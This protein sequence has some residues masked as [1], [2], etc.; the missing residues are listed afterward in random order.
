MCRDGSFEVESQTLALT[1]G[2]A[3]RAGL[4]RLTAMLLPHFE[5]SRRLAD[6][7]DGAASELEVQAD[8][9]ARYMDAALAV[10]RRLYE[11]GFLVRAGG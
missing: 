3:F 7:L 2:L 8:E 9:R 1:E 10:T 11:L 5:A 4:D 6:V